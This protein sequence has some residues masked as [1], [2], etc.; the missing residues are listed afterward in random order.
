MQTEN[1]AWNAVLPQVGIL[2]GFYEY[3]GQ[4]GTSGAVGA[5]ARGEAGPDPDPPAPHGTIRRGL[6][7]EGIIPKILHALAHGDPLKNLEDKQAVCKQFADL[8][9]FVMEFD[10][11][12]VRSRSQRP[13]RAAPWS[14][15]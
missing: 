1:E 2:K 13:R 8:L 7:A 11:L 3:A 15:R 5:T 14:L 4:I 6:T 12:K 9:W 10:E